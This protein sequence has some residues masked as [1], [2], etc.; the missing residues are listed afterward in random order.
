MFV[1]DY[2]I[3]AAGGQAMGDEAEESTLRLLWRGLVDDVRELR[4]LFDRMRNVE[5]DVAVIKPIAE[6]WKMDHDV[7]M[8]ATGAKG[9]F[10]WLAPFLQLII[11]G[12]LGWG[13]TEI[14]AMGRQQGI[15]TSDIAG[16]KEV[17]RERTFVPADWSD[18]RDDVAT[19]HTD[20][21]SM[22]AD[23]A[24]LTAQ[25]QALVTKKTVP[26]QINIKQPAPSVIV[27]PMQI[28]KPDQVKPRSSPSDGPMKRIFGK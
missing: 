21:T 27:Q 2:G 12:L 13:L 20:M 18:L 25:M 28:I 1:M 26:A 17:I 23:I 15:N 3:G 5:S 6:T 24:A 7:L 8:Q 4:S 14:V 11:I 16:L 10:K 22:K 19:V 9:L